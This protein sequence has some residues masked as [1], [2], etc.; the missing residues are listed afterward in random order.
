MDGRRLRL[1]ELTAELAH[2]SEQLEAAEPGLDARLFTGLDA[3]GDGTIALAGLREALARAISTQPPLLEWLVKAQEE[4]QTQG[5]RRAI[6][7]S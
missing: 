6:Q 4:G 7:I 1:P 3:R 2:R 5:R